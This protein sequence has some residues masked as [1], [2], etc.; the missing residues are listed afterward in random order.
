[1]LIITNKYIPHTFPSA[2]LIHC[3]FTSLSSAAHAEQETSRLKFIDS[4]RKITLIPAMAETKNQITIPKR[5]GDKQIRQITVRKRSERASIRQREPRYAFLSVLIDN[6][7]GT[8][9]FLQHLFASMPF[10]SVASIDCPQY[11][12]QCVTRHKSTLTQ[13]QMLKK[14]HKSFRRQSN[15]WR[16]FWV[17]QSFTFQMIELDYQTMV[18]LQNIHWYLCHGV[19]CFPNLAKSFVVNSLNG[20]EKSMTEQTA[21]NK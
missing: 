6:W 10:K 4:V 7:I 21:G 9:F 17:T 15:R 19:D 3:T 20:G 12:C 5:L 11:S 16:S 14:E 8:E 2:I 1:M 13:K 18:E